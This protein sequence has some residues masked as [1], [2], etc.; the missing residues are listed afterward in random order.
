MTKTSKRLVVLLGILFFSFSTTIPLFLVNQVDNSAE[1]LKTSANEITIVTPENITYTAG[2]NGYYSGTYGFESDLDGGNPSGWA[3]NEGG[4][5]INVISSLDGHE[6]V[7]EFSD[8]NGADTIFMTN[9]FVGKTTG[10]VECWVRINSTDQGFAIYIGDGGVSNAIRLNWEPDGLVKYQA[11]GL[12]P[13]EA[14]TADKWYHIK[15]EFDTSTDWHLW[16]D[17][18]SKDSGAGYNYVGTPSAMDIMYFDSYTP[19]T[20]CWFYIDAVGYSWDPVYNVGD[21]LNKG[22][23]VSYTNST[24]L[25]WKGY[26]LDNQ[27]NK[28]IIG[29][30]TI[31]LPSEG[32]HKIQMF[33][34]DSIG[35]NYE[36][37]VRYFTIGTSVGKSAPEINITTPAGNQLFGNSPPSFSLS[38]IALDLN[39]TWYSLDGGATNMTFSG[40]T[41]T[42]DQFEWDKISN[43]TVKIAFNANNS[44][45]NVG[46]AEVTVRKDIIAPVINIYQPIL[47]QEFIDIPPIFNV[48]II[49][50]NFNSS[51]YTVDGGLTNVTFTG[52]TGVIDETLWDSLSRGTI[53]IRFYA[54]DDVGNIGYST[55]HVVKNSPS[56]DSLSE[57]EIPG[58]NLIALIGVSCIVTFIILKKRT[59]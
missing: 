19:S 11:P 21:N 33:G 45:G 41:G 26:S 31:L 8:T 34:N 27:L 12:I 48:S 53:T 40:I 42:I 13:I 10:T 55:V 29:N 46:R 35:N 39:V 54:K 25:D 57:P 9:S 32:N 59:K 37:D 1:N 7:V 43:G 56:T 28:T 47:S 49:E 15:I 5:T 17:G 38:M 3:L 18:V 4:G 52:I 44:W 22:L 51:W 30:T 23:L 2:M 50:P 16:I 6:K 36:S 14:Y 24:N 20:S 58:Y